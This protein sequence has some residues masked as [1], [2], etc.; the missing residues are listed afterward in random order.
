M[1][2]KYPIY[3]WKSSPRKKDLGFTRWKIENFRSVGMDNEAQ[4]VELAPLTILCGDNSAGKSS[5]IKSILFMAQTFTNPEIEDKPKLEVMGNLVNIGAYLNAINVEVVGATDEDLAE[6]Q[7]SRE[8]Y[9]DYAIGDS[10]I[11]FSC[12]LDIP[13]SDYLSN[14]LLVQNPNFDSYSQIHLSYTFTDTGNYRDFGENATKESAIKK[15]LDGDLVVGMGASENYAELK[16]FKADFVKFFNSESENSIPYQKLVDLPNQQII[17]TPDKLAK[18]LEISPKT[19]R[20][21]LRDNFSKEKGTKWKLTKEHIEAAR[22]HWEKVGPSFKVDTLEVVDEFIPD[23][24]ANG[25]TLVRLEKEIER[26][27]YK[28]FWSGEFLTQRASMP[29]IKNITGGYSFKRTKHENRLDILNSFELNE[30]LD[31]SEPRYEYN[32]LGSLSG[33]VPRSKLVNRD[34]VEI[35]NSIS[36]EITGSLINAMQALEIELPSV[37]EGCFG[38]DM[39]PYDNKDADE[40]ERMVMENSDDFSEYMSKDTLTKSEALEKMN[41]IDAQLQQL[42][43]DEELKRRNLEDL[44][45]TEGIEVPIDDNEKEDSAD[46]NFFPESYFRTTKDSLLDEKDELNQILVGIEFNKKNHD[47]PTYQDFL[48]YVKEQMF[49]IDKFDLNKIPELSEILDEDN[50]P[51]WEYHSFKFFNIIENNLWIKS[52]YKKEKFEKNLDVADNYLK[53]EMFSDL[54]TISKDFELFRSIV[55]F[56]SVTF[57]LKQNITFKEFSKISSYIGSEKNQPSIH[58]EI[59]DTINSSIIFEDNVE[60]L[61]GEIRSESQDIT[62]ELELLKQRFSKIKYLGPLSELAIAQNSPASFPVNTPLGS[63]G[64][65]FYAYYEKNKGKKINVPVPNITESDLKKPANKRSVKFSIENDISLEVAMNKWL[66]FFDLADTFETIQDMQRGDIIAYIRPRNLDR[67]VQM[68]QIGVGFS[69]LA[70]IILLTL[71]SDS[72][73]TILIEQPEEHIHPAGQQRFANFAIEFAKNN[74]QM[75]IET[76]SDHIVNRLRREIVESEGSISNLIS[77][78]FVERIKGK[79]KF[80][81]SEIDKYGRYSSASFPEGF[82]DQHVDDSL[83]ILKARAK[84]EKKDDPTGIN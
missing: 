77:L 20:Q 38:V 71:V 17:T 29:D 51:D 6:M 32:F 27:K 73:D 26:G 5:F 84:F 25:R 67:K 49:D 4:E 69:Q 19:L 14:N 47:P 22:N 55:W 68:T 53:N 2:N 33:G 70:P 78:F 36:K 65:Y 46:S 45:F 16:H 72:G 60:V 18:E 15:H 75:I 57:M 1:S 64:E 7:I 66:Q 30:V 8:S 80:T 3:N 54:I 23:N 61:D 83:A 74:I 76:H 37:M 12:S 21:W 43:E 41:I 42:K 50:V 28:R 24:Q 62:A 81:E 40:W 56:L 13:A 39:T 63:G 59:N 82:F 52:F 44:Q 31:K 48:D 35:I 10:Y 58:D 11:N 79:T 9:L 34:K